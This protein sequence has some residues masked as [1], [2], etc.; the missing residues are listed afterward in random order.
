MCTLIKGSFQLFLTIF[1]NTVAEKK[2]VVPRSVLTFAGLVTKQSLKGTVVPA[3][4]VT[5]K[6]VVDIHQETK[7][8]DI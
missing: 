5:L 3:G 2:K 6:F 8:R 4:L 7:S 1:S